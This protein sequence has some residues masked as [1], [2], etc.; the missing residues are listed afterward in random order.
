VARARPALAEFRTIGPPE[1]NRVVRAQPCGQQLEATVAQPGGCRQ[2]DHAVG[3]KAGA[4][5]LVGREVEDGED[6]DAGQRRLSSDQGPA[7]RS[8]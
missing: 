8:A 7:V 5:Q 1:A 6:R 3:G 2:V 4:Q